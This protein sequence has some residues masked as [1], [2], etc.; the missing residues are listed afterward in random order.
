MKNY[1]SCFNFFS[2]KTKYMILF[3][4]E[5]KHASNIAAVRDILITFGEAT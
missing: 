2:D 3:R 4:I 1:K 5:I